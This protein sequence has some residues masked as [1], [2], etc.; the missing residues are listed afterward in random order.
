VASSV[1]IRISCTDARSSQDKV[2]LNSG[3]DRPWSRYFCCVI[4]AN[5][6]FVQRNPVAT[7]RALR[8]I[9]K[10]SDIC[11]AEPQRAAQLLTDK[12]IAPSYGT[13]LQVLTELPYNRWREYDHEDT[14]RFYSLRLNEIGMIKSTPDKIIQ[15]GTDWRFLNDLK[16]ELKT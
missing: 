12:G 2:I 3:S 14:V 7:K 8:A 4:G 5:R 15:Q 11:A 13:A 9:L 16:Q 10:A 6:E 1:A